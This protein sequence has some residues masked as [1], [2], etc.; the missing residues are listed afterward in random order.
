MK[1]LR[2]LSLPVLLGCLGLLSGC[3][4]GT[5]SGTSSYTPPT[6]SPG[7]VLKVGVTPDMAPMVFKQAG[8]LTGFEIEMAREFGKYLER[9]VEF[10]QVK[11]AD[12]LT[13]LQNGR[14]DIVMSSMSITP[15]RRMLAAFSNPYMHVGQMM[16]V[17]RKD[18]YRYALGFPQ[19]LPGTV[20]VQRGT[21]GEYV[22]EEM[23]AHSKKKTYRS[24]DDAV[25][26]LANKRIDS[27][28]S[29]AQIVLY[30]AALN[31][32]A[33]LTVIPRMLHEDYLGWAVR[34]QD[35]ELLTKVNEF[36]AKTQK[37]DSMNATIK[38]WMPLAQ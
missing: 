25:K 14:T 20:G 19:P 24:I 33:S 17:H 1:S 21:V 13:A 9:P 27:V 7:N 28:I 35:T 10:V 26:D 2:T 4:S 37:D 23:F 5:D 3:Q 18:L 16:L 12:Q 29:D 11:W 36:I 15:Q 30:Q 6:D 8:K 38:R 32:T 31:Q 22:V 34:P